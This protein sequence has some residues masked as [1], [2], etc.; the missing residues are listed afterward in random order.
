M[1]CAIM[2]EGLTYKPV[3]KTNSKTSQQTSNCALSVTFSATISS[4][5]SL[6]ALG[7]P[8]H[9]KQLTQIKPIAE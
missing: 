3:S 8:K 5:C 9:P 2:S 1:N 4:F 6:V 7:L